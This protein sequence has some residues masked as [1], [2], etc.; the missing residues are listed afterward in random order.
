M[1]KQKMTISRSEN[2]SKIRSK[3]TAIE[4]KLRKELWKR[5]YR[6]KIH[7]KD[8]FGKPDI[9]FKSKKI[10][11]FCDSSFWH[12]KDY[13]EGKNI[14]KS[15]NAFWARKLLTNIERDKKV[16]SELKKQG[17]VVIRILEN[18][19]K[20]D[21]SSCVD[22]IENTIKSYFGKGMP[23]EKVEFD[24]GP[25]AV[26]KLGEDLYKNIYGVLIE[27]ITN[28][29]D[30][31]ADIVNIS[32][33]R[34]KKEIIIKDDGI[35]MSYEELKSDYMR[36]GLNRRKKAPEKTS[37]G[38]LVTGR[39]G[40]GKLACF[41]LFK[42]FKLET[43]KDNWKSTLVINTGYNDD[44]DF[45]YTAMINKESEKVDLPNG[46]TIYLLNHIIKNIPD[47][48]IIAE[49]IAK[50][51]NIM[52]GSMEDQEKFAIKLED[53]WIDKTFRDELVLNKDIR[54]SYLIPDNLERFTKDKDIIEYINKNKIYGII[55]AREHTVNLRENKGVVLFARGKLCQEATYLNINPSNSFGYAHL[56]AE[57]HVDFI[58]HEKA[59][60]I[61]TDRTALKETE[62]TIKLFEVIGALMKAYATLYDD[63]VS[64]RKNKAMEIYKNED[65]NY[66]EIKKTI[67]IISDKTIRNELF[68]LF[69][70]KIRESIKNSS[71]DTAGIKK[72]KFIAEAVTPTYILTSDQI[73]KN[74]PKDNILTSY[75]HLMQYFRNKYDYSSDDGKK[76]IQGL[77]GNSSKIVQLS[78]LTDCLPDNVKTDLK[79]AARELG[80]G[81]VDLR[82]A[83]MHT[84]NRTQ[85]NE[86][87]SIENSKRFLTMIDL[88]TELD[89]MFFE[90]I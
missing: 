77:F 30:A 44:G 59:D 11:I 58:D 51:L 49:S 81:I 46:T 34:L 56:Y 18:E 12:G 5:G 43:I 21:V 9:C 38:R 22:V 35:G 74:E 79:N 7:C 62:T 70:I 4:M 60:N 80:E 50:R 10:A 82:N 41:G 90:K 69:D 40:F 20:K 71:V 36:V 65:E 2:M 37:K 87:I 31:D 33:D 53:I 78:K 66:K 6:Y 39:K 54:F 32:I 42:N 48:K 67:D 84:N 8:I 89:K 61:G 64:E 68:A 24:V 26:I 88:F 73:S 29:Y 52:Y 45:Y 75:D 25:N 72:F 55:I 23:M 57:L 14:P 27:Y 19:I 1:N 76:A 15:N 16:N 3:N 85:I 83:I 63:D 28:S 47:N 86:N 17:W 13:L